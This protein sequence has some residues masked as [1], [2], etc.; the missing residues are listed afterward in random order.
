MYMKESLSIGIPNTCGRLIGSIGYFL[1]P[2][3]LSMVLHY[4][5]YSANF[6]TNQYGILSG[7]VMPILLLPSFFTGAI[8]NALLPII[9]KE[10]SLK[11]YDQAKRKLKL[12]IILSLGIG[13]ILMSLFILMP[14]VFLKMIYHTNQ[15]IS[16]MRFLAPVC[17]LQYIQA[18]LSSS[19]EA[20]G[21]SK[22][23]FISSLLGVFTRCILLV[24]LSLFNIGLWG[25]I[26][27]IS[28]NV[29]VVTI[30]EAVM[31]RKFL[32]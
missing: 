17:L 31:V 6:I 7:Y 10:Y 20:M 22:V 18:P 29:F 5:G 25:L 12:S 2:I 21:K 23:V 8:S 30:Y 3:L 4:V 1:E 27:A 15:G 32:Q 26:L 24:V 28:V 9:S 16:Y 19:L 11:H 14:G 13:I